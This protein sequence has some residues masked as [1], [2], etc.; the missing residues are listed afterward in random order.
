MSIK[1]RSSEDDSQK[2]TLSFWDDVRENEYLV[3]LDEDTGEDSVK[4][5]SIPNKIRSVGLSKNCL[6]IKIE[7][8][9]EVKWI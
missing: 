4:A 1:K 6:L 7:R 8:I 3:V 5:V 2:K 9:D